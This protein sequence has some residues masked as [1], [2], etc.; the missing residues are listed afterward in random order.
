MGKLVLIRHGQS[1]WN[2]LNTFTGWQDPDITD[3]GRVEAVEGGKA[4]LTAG[5]EVDVMHTSLLRRAITT[6]NLA[7]DAA[8]RS[9]IPVHRHWRLNERHYGALQGLNKK[10]TEDK[11]GPEQFLLWRRSYDVPPPPVDLASEHHPA[12]DPRYAN[13]AP[14]LLPPTECLKDVLE[15]TLPYWFDAIVPQLHEKKTVAISAHGNSIRALAK[16]LLHISD[17]D[18]VSLEIPHGKP[19]IFDFDAEFQVTN[20]AYL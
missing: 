11:H 15:R 9:W 1:E 13:V 5:I 19:W 4:L 7:L 16:H 2:L 6:A 17:E 10:E 14:E 8:D 20:E 18:I 12:N 3:Q